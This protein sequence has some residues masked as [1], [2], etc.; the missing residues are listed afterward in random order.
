MIVKKELKIQGGL[1]DLE[2]KE[3]QILRLE[4]K[5]NQQ[6]F[7]SDL[8]NATKTNKELSDLKKQF[9]K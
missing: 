4:E 8:E 7:W 6:D 9:I 1:F 3:N 5:V 2:G